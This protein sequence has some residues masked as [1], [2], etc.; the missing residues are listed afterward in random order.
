MKF[1]EPILR[2]DIKAAENYNF[3]K[4]KPL[5]VPITTF[6]GSD[7][8]ITLEEVELWQSET[9]MGFEKFEFSGDHFFL[10][11]HFPKLCQ[12]INIRILK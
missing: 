5:K 7:E 3:Q 10:Q 2:A 4:T 12:I 1:Y 9:T 6:Y 8:D 11:E